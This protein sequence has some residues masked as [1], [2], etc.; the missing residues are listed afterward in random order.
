MKEPSD[1]PPIG[2]PFFQGFNAR[3]SFTPVMNVQDFQAGLAK[4]PAH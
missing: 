2:E 1:L 4:K 3:I